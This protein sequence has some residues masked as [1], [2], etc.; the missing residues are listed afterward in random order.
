[1]LQKNAGNP[2]DFKEIAD[3]LSEMIECNVYIVG[4]KGKIL[5]YSF[6]EGF[7]CEIIEE[8]INEFE[9]FPEEYNEKLLTVTQSQAN[10]KAEK[11]KCV[12]QGPLDVNFQ[13]KFPQ[14]FPFWVVEN[15]KEL[16][17]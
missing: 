3:V 7:N 17:Y 14:L 13:V 2:V 15:G 4:R 10:I 6:L 8:I 5:G 9:R 12:F 16:C 11:N 1:M